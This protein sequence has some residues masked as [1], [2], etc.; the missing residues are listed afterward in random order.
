MEVQIEIELVYRNNPPHQ[1][2]KSHRL[3]SLLFSFG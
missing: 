1:E 3:R 2:R